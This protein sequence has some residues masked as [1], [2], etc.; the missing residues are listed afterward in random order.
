MWGVPD[1]YP[2]GEAPFAPNRP[3]GLHLSEDFAPTTEVDFFNLFLGPE[4]LVYIVEFTNMYA[5]AHIDAHLS[6]KNKDGKSAYQQ[7]VLAEASGELV[8]INTPKGLF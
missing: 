3:P 1:D 4:Q 6:Y 8:T 7:S 5:Q 2:V